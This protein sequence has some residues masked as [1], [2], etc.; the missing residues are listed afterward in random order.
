M[1]NTA[2]TTATATTFAPSSERLPNAA[3]CPRCGNPHDVLRTLSFTTEAV[4]REC[5][6][7]DY[8]AALAHRLATEPHVCFACGGTTTLWAGECHLC[9]V[10]VVCDCG[11]AAEVAITASWSA[12]R[13]C[14]ADL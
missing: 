9:G 11:A 1:L 6:S 10:P 4:C 8:E 5:C 3:T 2:T 12:C 14:A 13:E 7:A